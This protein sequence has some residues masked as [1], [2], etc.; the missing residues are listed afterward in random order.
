MGKFPDFPIVVETFRECLDHD[1]ELSRLRSFLDAIAAGAIRVV[2]RQGEI[3]SPFASELIFLFTPTY[4]YEW[5]EPRRTDLRPPGT[6]VDEDLLESLLQ[7]PD[8]NRLLDPQAVGRVEGRLRLRGLAPRTAEEMAETLRALGDL[9]Q[10]ELFGPMEKLLFELETQGRVCRI[11]LDGTVEPRRWISAEE[12]EL[13]RIAFD[14]GDEPDSSALE[15][16]VRRHLRTHALIGLSDCTNRYPISPALASELL[17]R[18][19]ESGSVIRL[20]PGEDT[21]GPAWAERENLAE[22]RRL[23]VA[24]R[25]RESV[26]VPPEVFADFLVRQQFLDA[27]TRAEGPEGLEQVLERLQGYAVSA[28]FWENEILPRRVRNYRPA[29]LDD[30]LAGGA[31][32]WRGA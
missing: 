24:I 7:G 14:S 22:I 29:W 31:W 8:T 19:V 17:E 28:E 2:T 20:I 25:R 10:S 6:V 15:T 23:T 1:L 26:A 27:S 9:S 32:P 21:L 3:A 30:L 18:S 11:M 16:I 5:D 13:Y 4:L 12:S